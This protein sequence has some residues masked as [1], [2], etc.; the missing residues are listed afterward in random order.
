MQENPTLYAE[1]IVELLSDVNYSTADA[2]LKLARVLLDYRATVS[3]A[4]QSLHSFECPEAG[5]V[6]SRI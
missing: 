6:E 4:E 1:K 2:S 5:A 3:V